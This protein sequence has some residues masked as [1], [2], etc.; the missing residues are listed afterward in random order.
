M[1]GLTSLRMQVLGPAATDTLGK[2]PMDIGAAD[3]GPPAG[4][5][6]SS[7]CAVPPPVQQRSLHKPSSV[8]LN[9]R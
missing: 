9:L 1:A 4:P 5:G 6:R 3:A 2:G 8:G 7:S